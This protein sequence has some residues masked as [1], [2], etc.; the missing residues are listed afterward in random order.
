[1]EL[2]EG[3]RKGGCG[4][5]RGGFYRGREAPGRRGDVEVVGDG[6]GFV[7]V[8]GRG[9]EGVVGCGGVVVGVVAH[10]RRTRGGWRRPL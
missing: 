4:D 9:D 10:V 7:G 5:P 2:S 6:C 3:L 8:T 1:M